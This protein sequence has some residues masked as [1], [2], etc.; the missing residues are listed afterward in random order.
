MKTHDDFLE[1][2][3]EYFNKR[4]QEYTENDKTYT[5]KNGNICMVY[6]IKCEEENY[7]MAVSSGKCAW[8][9]FDA[10]ADK[11]KVTDETE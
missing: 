7:F 4:Y 5:D 9:G 8:C 11:K 6:C 1:E 10:N 3:K 2:L